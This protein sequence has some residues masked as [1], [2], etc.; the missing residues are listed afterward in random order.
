MPEYPSGFSKKLF[1]NRQKY[2]KW[3]MVYKL[4]HTAVDLQCDTARLQRVIITGAEKVRVMRACH[5]GVNGSH[6]GRD[7]T[8]SK[9]CVI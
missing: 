7:K 8:L 5:G 9:V 4:F 6:F 1:G 2:L 3:K